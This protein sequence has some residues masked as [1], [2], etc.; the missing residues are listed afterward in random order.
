ML[1]SRFPL[2]EILKTLLKLKVMLAFIL[3]NKM[4]C[5]E[6]EI[7]ISYV[8]IIVI[9]RAMNF[10]FLCVC[11]SKQTSKNFLTRIVQSHS[12]FICVWLIFFHFLG[13]GGLIYT[14]FFSRIILKNFSWNWFHGKSI[15][16]LCFVNI[17][18]VLGSGMNLHLSDNDLVRSIFGLGAPLPA[19]DKLSSR[20]SK[21]ERVRK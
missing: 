10:N 3:L 13:S 2:K 4:C 5:V 8:N 20:P 18:Q 11:S 16:Y 1:Y 6:I 17:F 15:L 12:A 19:L 14:S 21:H 9:Q 7:E